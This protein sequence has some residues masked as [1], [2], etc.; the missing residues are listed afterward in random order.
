MKQYKL[1]RSHYLALGKVLREAR[2]KTIDPVSTLK[3][4]VTDISSQLHV[5]PGFVY[6]VEQGIRK[7]KDRDIAVWASVYG[8]KYETLLKC[9]HRIPFD[10]VATLKEQT[11]LHV[12]INDDPFSHLTEYEKSQLLPYLEY[13]RWK[14]SLRVP[15]TKS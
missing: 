14:N 4:S 8:I 11:Q 12:P 5:T 13:I 1:R 9:L 2:E 10:F 7:P 6:Q 15:D 3:R